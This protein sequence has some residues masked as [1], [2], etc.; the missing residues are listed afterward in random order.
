MIEVEI[1]A[2]RKMLVSGC[3]RRSGFSSTQTFN[4]ML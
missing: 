1:A 3:W 2:K 4:E